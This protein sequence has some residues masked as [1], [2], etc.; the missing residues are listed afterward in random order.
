LRERCGFGVDDCG[1]EDGPIIYV[2][3]AAYT[4]MHVINDLEQLIAGASHQTKVIMVVYAIHTLGMSYSTT[5]LKRR[6]RAAGKSLEIAWCYEM[7]MENSVANV[8]DVLWPKSIP[9][10]DE[11]KQYYNSLTRRIELRTGDSTGKNGLFS[12]AAARD[13]LEQ[14][15]LKRGAMI[16][17][18]NQNLKK[19]ARPLGNC[20]LQSLGFGTLIVTFRNCANNSPLVFW[21]GD[22]P[23]FERDNN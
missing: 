7:E 6:F 22:Y 5:E 15:F 13:L 21:A 19:Y 10:H 2:D 23:L 3:D 9:D 8:S 12:S 11:S 20:V 16:R 18:E 17:A 14:E 1:S 4:G